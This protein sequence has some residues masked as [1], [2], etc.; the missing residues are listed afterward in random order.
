M[1]KYS[2]FAIIASFLG[3]W[4]NS[5]LTK[6][7]EIIVGFIL[8]LSFGIIHGANDLYIIKNIKKDNTKLNYSVL[9]LRYIIVVSLGAL[10]FYVLP[11]LALSLFIL[12]SGYHFGE[13]HWNKKLAMERQWVPLLYETLYGLII[14]FLIF[15]FNSN[16]VHTIIA[17]ITAITFPLSYYLLVLKILIVI[18]LL[19]SVY[20]YSKIEQFKKYIV[21]ELFYLIFFALLFKVSSLIWGFALYFIIWHSIP[22]MI[23]QIKFLHDEVNYPK[24]ILYV[25]SGFWYWIVS[26]LG[27]GILYILFE[28]QKIFNALFFSFI[29][30]ITFPH[31]LVI[32]HMYKKKSTVINKKTG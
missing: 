7:I 20:F 31:V 23:D 5:F 19:M 30:S 2:N 3:L 6:E 28:N 24:L 12:I 18:Y 4:L 9:L 15:T 21:Q 29:A 11:W 16:E 1:S 8:I 10:L 13:Q 14:L 32:L 26:L 22:S 27:I 17:T 25:R